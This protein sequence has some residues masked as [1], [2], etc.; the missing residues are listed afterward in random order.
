[1]EDV[2]HLSVRGMHVMAFVISIARVNRFNGG[3]RHLC[4]PLAGRAGD[5]YC[6]IVRGASTRYSYSFIATLHE[7][8][9]A[10]KR[11]NLW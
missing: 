3:S 7:H 8:V 11:F 2:Q 1:M 6:V 4:V 9:H 5:A 10:V